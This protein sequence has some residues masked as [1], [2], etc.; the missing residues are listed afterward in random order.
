MFWSEYP[1]DVVR[2][3]GPDAATYLQSQ[4]SQDIRPLGVGDSAWSFLLQ[5]TGRVDVLLRVWRIGDDEFVLDTDAGF[6]EVMTARLLRFRIRVKAEVQALDWSCIAVRGGAV[7][8][9]VPSWGDGTDMLAAAPVPP[10]GVRQGSTAELLAARIDAA[11]PAMGL[12]IVPGETIPA[13]TGITDVAV[14]FRKGCY[15]GQ[16]LVERMD[17]RAATA[18]R[19][20]RRLT[21][22]EASRLEAEVTSAAGELVLA[23]VSRRRA[24]D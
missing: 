4:L 23:Y 13:E 2:V 15:P 16:E 22:E 20:L 11:W 14:N 12:E 24:A 8:G 17:S 6:G 3:A 18:P 7:D 9:G 10:A 19:L 5:P 1:R 21:A